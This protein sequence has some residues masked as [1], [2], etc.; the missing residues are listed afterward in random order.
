[1]I[2]RGPNKKTD[3]KYKKIPCQSL[4]FV[5]NRTANRISRWQLDT[6]PSCSCFSFCNYFF[7]CLFLVEWPI[8]GLGLA[9]FGFLLDYF[10]QCGPTFLNVLL[11][12]PPLLW[13]R[14]SIFPCLGPV[15]SLVLSWSCPLSCIAKSCLHLSELALSCLALTSLALPTLALPCLPLPW[16]S[17]SCLAWSCLALAF[18]ILPYVIWQ[19]P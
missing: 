5:L 19:N 9:Q 11:S 14:V 1:M 13:S 18:L 12:P 8:I 16:L 10:L 6:F 17:S 7:S 15:L 3:W 4:N 2:G